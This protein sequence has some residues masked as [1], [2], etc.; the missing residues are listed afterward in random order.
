MF[1]FRFKQH[2]LCF[3]SIRAVGVIAYLWYV[4]VSAFTKNIK[5]MSNKENKPH[6]LV[7]F[8]LICVWGS[9]LYVFVL[10]W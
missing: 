1:E 4:S 10:F 6:I 3:I 5:L 2:I 7:Q 8:L 9:V